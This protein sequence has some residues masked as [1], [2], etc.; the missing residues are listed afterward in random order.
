MMKLVSSL[1]FCA[2]ACAAFA[3]P[4]ERTCN[5]FCVGPVRIH[6]PEAG[7]WTFAPQGRFFAVLSARQVAALTMPVMRIF[8]SRWNSATARSVPLPKMPSALPRR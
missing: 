7:G 6:A 3:A 5:G 1:S 4:F 2:F 8:W